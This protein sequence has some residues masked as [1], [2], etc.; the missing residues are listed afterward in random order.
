MKS[1]TYFDRSNDFFYFS[2]ARIKTS[3]VLGLLLF[4]E[5]VGKGH[6]LVLFIVLSLQCVQR[7]AK[8]EEQKT[9]LSLRSFMELCCSAA[10]LLHSGRE[11]NFH[12]F[13]LAK[14]GVTV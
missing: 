5:R 2:C 7:A 3:H 14:W 10:F 12:S 13:I 1:E 8:A 9:D 11:G 4:C 6:V